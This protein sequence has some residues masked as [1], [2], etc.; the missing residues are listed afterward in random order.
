[1]SKIVTIR[2]MVLGDGNPK[3]CVPVTE[4]GLEEM[5]Q[6]IQEIKKVPFDF[7]EWRADFYSGLMDREKRIAALRLLR[8]ELGEI[9]VLFTLR[10]KAE[11]G[12][13][14]PDPKTYRKVLLDVIG[15][16]LAD[17]A[18]V[19]LSC[20]EETMKTIVSAAHDKN[21][22]II[23]SRHDFHATPEAS[24]IL[25]CLCRMQELGADL[26]KYAVMPRC[27]RDVLTLL[28][29]TLTMKE[30]FPE[31]PVITMSMGSLGAVSR[32]CG[33]LTGSCVTFGSV[34]KSSA[35]GQLPADTLK[36]FLKALS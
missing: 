15:T 14:E 12:E 1:M 24:E 16:G 32:I 26:V 17:L 3:I 27:E 33:R 29:A 34:G 25:S 35:P 5:E 6:S 36:Q 28:D 10:T 13:I 9:P 2:D 18:D 11:G 31:T 21:I 4:P 30:K 20:G 7:V 8:K 22:T 19:E 23:A